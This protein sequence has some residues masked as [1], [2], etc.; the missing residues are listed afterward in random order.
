MSIGSTIRQ[1]R[2]QSE[3]S[4]RELARRAGTSHATLLA[5]EAGRVDPGSK[6]VERILLAAGFRARTV[7][8]PVAITTSGR[9]TGDELADLLDLAEH[10]PHRARSRHLGA[11]IFGRRS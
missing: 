2:Q 5:Y 3:L 10:L 9:R 8:E 1:A 11:P 7:L 6:V 4:V